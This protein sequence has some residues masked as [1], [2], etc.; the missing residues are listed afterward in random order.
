MSIFYD[1]AILRYAVNVGFQ[2]KKKC[3]G[4]WVGRFMAVNVNPIT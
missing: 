3:S 1:A 4:P 2:K